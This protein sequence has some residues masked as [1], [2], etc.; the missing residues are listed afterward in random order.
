MRRVVLDTETTGLEWAGADRVIEIA[1]VALE[2]TQLTGE[3]W[4]T[5]LNPG[6][7][8]TPGAF[9]IHK[10]TDAFLE[11]KPQFSEAVEDLIDFIGNDELI[12]H[13]LLGFDKHFLNKELKLVGKPELD[14][15]MTDT[16]LI[17]RSI[18]PGKR[19]TLDALCKEFKIQNTRGGVHGALVDADL[20]AR[21]Y[22]HLAQA[23]GTVALDLAPSQEDAPEIEYGGQIVVKATAEEL[24]LHAAMCKELGIT[25]WQ[26][27]LQAAKSRLPSPT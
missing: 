12:G 16:L 1:C 3:Y 20:N 8:I 13:N 2:G 22:A 17:A 9:S 19:N 4:Q 7:R 26:R 18:R 14:N 24:D 23:A 10:I 25:S 27:P 6:V 5:Y 11:D 15:K 21:V